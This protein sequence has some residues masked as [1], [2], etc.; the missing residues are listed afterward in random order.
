MKIFLSKIFWDLSAGGHNED[1][2]AGSCHSGGETQ[3]RNDG[4]FPPAKGKGKT[5]DKVAAY[6][7]VSGRR[8]GKAMAAGGKFGLV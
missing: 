8:L 5:R 4:K 3:K 2:G 6:E 1:V 7:W